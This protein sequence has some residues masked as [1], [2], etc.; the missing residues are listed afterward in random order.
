[1]ATFLLATVGGTGREP[2]VTPA[3]GKRESEVMGASYIRRKSERKGIS[4]VGVHGEGGAMETRKL[5]PLRATLFSLRCQS[6]RSGHRR[7]KP[8]SIADNVSTLS[9]SLDV[10]HKTRRKSHTAK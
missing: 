7:Q 6:E 10:T 8:S 4:C 5:H 2:G 1:M 9:T 3:E